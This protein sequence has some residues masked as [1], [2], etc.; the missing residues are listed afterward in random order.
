M[1]GV[2]GYV[3]S[4]AT[5]FVAGVNAAFAARGAVPPLP[6]EFTAHGAL[7]RYLVDADP[8]RVSSR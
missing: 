4:A 1:T 8:R 7:L 2:E 3:E 6:D 5:G